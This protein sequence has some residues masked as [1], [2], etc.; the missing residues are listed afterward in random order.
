MPECVY[1]FKK[2]YCSKRQLSPTGSK[3][4]LVPWFSVELL[5]QRLGEPRGLLAF[6]HLW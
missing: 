1:L 3:S 5:P 6:S 4:S 2:K